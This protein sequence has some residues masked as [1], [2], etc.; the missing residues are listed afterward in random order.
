MS[1]ESLTLYKLMTLYMLNKVN[2]PLTDAQISRFFL[3]KEYTNYFT[4]R[5]MISELIET[6]L[7]T[8]ETIRNASYYKIANDGIE[9]IELFTKKIPVA[10]IDDIDI[11]LLENKYELRNEVGTLCDYY[12]STNQ[13]YIV[14]CQI[15]EGPN[16]L[17]DI[18]LSVP[19][20]D[21][22]ETMCNNWKDASKDLYSTIMKTLM[23]EK[24]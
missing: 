22:A 19:S 1:L 6:K 12:K 23:K 15:K 13:D 5:E 18:N 21:V 3:D 11:F 9:T 8:S 24:Q 10:I 17:I 4:F 7:I 14:N 2:F 20:E 16:T